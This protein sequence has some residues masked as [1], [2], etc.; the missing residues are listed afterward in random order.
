MEQFLKPD[1]FDVTSNDANAES[2][3]R[4]WKQTFTNFLNSISKVE[5][6]DKLPLLSNYVSSNVFQYINECNDYNVAIDTLDKLYITKRNEIFA[7]HCLA[8]R[9][10]QVGESVQEYLQILQQMSKDCE[11]KAV[12]GELYKNEYV[13]D[14]FIRGLRNIRIRERILE[15]TT[16]TLEKAFDQ[17]RALE[18]AELH[19]ASYLNSQTS[20]AAISKIH[21]ESYEAEI[22]APM[23]AAAAQNRA[24][25]C[26]FCGNYF[27]PRSACPARN[28]T[29]RGCGKEGHFQK[30]C[31]S[32]SSILSK[33]SSS[34]SMHLSAASNFSSSLK[35][36]IIKILVNG[37]ELTALIDTGS[38]LSFIHQ[39]WVKKCQLRVQHYLGKITMA[40][41]SLISDIAGRCF[42]NLQIDAHSYPNVE[43][44]VMNN[45]CVDFLIGL[46]I[47]TNHSSLAIDFKG[48]RPPLQICAIALAQIPP[49]S[50]FLN[51]T[52]D[53]E[54]SYL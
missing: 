9:C 17:A 22:N 53:W 52:P 20:T 45:L 24:K 5:E 4:H 34:A 8:S 1:R 49:V 48:N 11:F 29:C 10:Q 42:L 12:D 36:S 30:V 23:S 47:L 7:R 43:V 16:I 26:F 18:L 2:K 46:D 19:S 50:L 28:V 44:L 21:E 54:L 38:S 32:R 33:K 31:K 40:N 25:K 14:A 41:S 27:H 39:Q 3:W 51:V 13:R 37:I 6:S 35:R 15:N